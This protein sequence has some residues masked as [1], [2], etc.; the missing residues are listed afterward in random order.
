MG[1][2]LIGICNRC[3]DAYD[4][5]EAS[6]FE[7]NFGDQCH[8][9]LDGVIGERA[10]WAAG[11][12]RPS[13]TETKSEVVDLNVNCNI[14]GGVLETRSGF[15]LRFHGSDQSIHKD[16][17]HYVPPWQLCPCCL[18]TRPLDPATDRTWRLLEMESCM[19]L[20]DV[21][22]GGARIIYHQKQVESITGLSL[23]PKKSSKALGLTEDSAK[24]VFGIDTRRPLKIKCGSCGDIMQPSGNLKEPSVPLQ[25]RGF[26]PA[27]GEIEVI[28][29]A[30]TLALTCP[31]CGR[32]DL[33]IYNAP[34][35]KWTWAY[36]RWV[37]T[38]RERFVTIAR[39]PASNGVLIGDL[40][41]DEYA[42]VLAQRPAASRASTD[43]QDIAAA[44]PAATD[45][46]DLTERLRLELENKPADA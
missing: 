37:R 34:R 26:H 13:L 15:E 20:H 16:T 27:R 14:C 31:G 42:A 32:D 35:K 44:A 18:V 38:P 8:F 11:D 33:F 12:E 3:G 9:C 17:G 19:D 23:G 28:G 24:K 21:G 39:G 29:L 10:D 5:S 45:I 6:W 40:N 46:D 43:Q 36:T 7:N 1:Q 30:P 2:T 41:M 22:Q 25:S 4:S